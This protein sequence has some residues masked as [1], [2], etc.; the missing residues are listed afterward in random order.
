MKGLILAGGTGSRMYPITK[1]VNKHLLLV[2][3][4]PMIYYPIS[5]LMMLGVKEFLITT[6]ENYLDDFI[7]LLGN[8]IDYGISIEYK[9]QKEAD[10]LA[11]ALK[12]ADGFITKNDKFIM[13]LGDNF[14]F[15]PSMDIIFK[16]FIQEN[17]ASICLK[18]VNNPES[19][20]IA[21]L[22]KNGNVSSIV[23]KPQNHISN[24]AVTGIYYYDYRA[25]EF[26][27][28]IQKSNRGELEITDIN[29]EYIKNNAMN[30]ITLNRSA[31]W[32]DCGTYESLFDASSFVCAIKKNHSFQPGV[33]EEVA[34]NKGYIN[35]DKFKE[36]IN[37]IKSCEYKDYL[38][39]VLSEYEINSDNII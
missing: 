11:G 1:S 9:I 31:V 39:M 35:V 21:N 37:K 10:G 6:H 32:F 17:K 30:Y 4:L 22:D 2:H 18:M 8:C 34:L 36:Q 28:V 23:E 19:F 33:L 29:N 12:V 14:F 38:C 5:F 13:I 16:N 7:K 3:N 15:I 20:G 27:N 26:A 25:I 24:L